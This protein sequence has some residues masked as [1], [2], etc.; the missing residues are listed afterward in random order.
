MSPLLNN[1]EEYAVIKSQI[2][3]LKER[4]EGLKEEIIEEMAEKGEDKVDTSVGKF[5]ISKLK[6]WTYTPKVAELN[7]EFKAQK[8]HEESTGLATFVEEPSLRFT[9]VSL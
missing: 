6:K 5:T 7:E 1:Y 2:K 8:A 4:E 3:K 9:K